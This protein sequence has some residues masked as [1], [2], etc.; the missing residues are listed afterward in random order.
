MEWKNK[1]P[2]HFISQDR[3]GSCFCNKHLKITVAYNKEFISCLCYMSSRGQQRLCTML[4][5]SRTRL[6]CSP[7]LLEQR[8]RE[9]GQSSCL[10]NH[11]LGQSKP[12]GQTQFQGAGK[13][14]PAGCPKGK[15]A[16][17][18]WRHTH[19]GG[20]P[21]GDYK[22]A[23]TLIVAIILENMKQECEICSFWKKAT[24]VCPTLF[25]MLLYLL[26]FQK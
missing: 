9:L 18:W 11:P 23:S 25:A 12:H 20:D 1:H 26:N 22:G 10:S 17:G 3:L 15:A 16:I 24:W 21:W 5:H 2:T 4:S 7:Q 13:S 8:E 14:Y 6:T 19:D